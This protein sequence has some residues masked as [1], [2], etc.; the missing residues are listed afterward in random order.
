MTTDE[1]L[2]EIIRLLRD[3]LDAIRSVE[4]SVDSVEDA[5]KTY[6]L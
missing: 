6:N 2:D 1:K 5:V 3:I 4:R